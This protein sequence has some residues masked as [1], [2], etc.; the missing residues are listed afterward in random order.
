MYLMALM[1]LSD[2]WWWISVIFKVSVGLGAVIFVHELGH[3][4]V[5]KL[6]GVKCEKFMIGFDIGGYKLAKRWGETLYGI[7]ILPLGGYVKML[8][9]DDDPAHIKEQMEKSQLDPSSENA[10]PITGPDGET[11]YVDR[12]SYLAKSVP[13]RM[14]IISAGVVM[15]IIFAFIFAVIAYGMGVPYVPSIVGETMAGGPAWQAGLQP[16]DEIVKIGNRTDPTFMQLMGG[17]TLG[18]LENG[19]E[20]EV[21]R[22]A[23]GKTERVPL[24]PKR[25]EG[26]VAMIGITSPMSL[27]LSERQATM[28]DSP[29]VKATLVSPPPPQ[30]KEGEAKFQ[31][32]D[33][34]VQVGTTP[35]ANYREF[36]AQLAGQPDKP[37]QIVVERSADKQKNKKVVDQ[38]EKQEAARLTFEVPSQ[39]LKDF[40]LVM[41]IGPITAVQ[42]NTPGDAAGL[43]A[44]DVIE[45][46]DGK[47]A[48]DDSW[49]PDTLPDLMRQA[50]EQKRTVDIGVSRA[51]KNGTDRESVNVKVTPRVPT[52][53]YTAVPLGSPQGIEAL[54]IAYQIT[55]QVQAVAASGPAANSGIKAGDKITAARIV[56][57]K[58]NDGKTPPPVKLELG[59]DAQNWVA[60]VDAVQFV[61]PETFVEFK[62]SG[63][64][65][66]DARDA[67][68]TPAPVKGAFH[69]P[70]GF[71]FSPVKRTRVAATF[72]DQLRYGW[73]ET[74]DALTMVVRFLRKLGGQI[75][76][77][78][79]GGP[80]TIAAAAGGAASQG[81]SSLLIFL[82]ML[83]ANLAVLN[84]LPIPLLDG[85]HFVFL[86]YEGIRGRPA[87]EKFVIALHTAGFIFIV[88]LMLFVIGLDIKRWIFT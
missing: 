2:L 70:R 54:G 48:G 8:G 21:R 42:A 51:A 36:A 80:G 45:T 12:R 85:G 49:T 37:L 4:L 9:Q 64:G 47:P 84:F 27:T 75:P 16:G 69:A 78:M 87:N 72:S 26:Q 76:L 53:Y 35:V 82:T 68:I 19:I 52:M 34:V 46:V 38:D 39:P 67:K 31:G 63:E 18:D 11:Y 33:K 73:D 25:K 24:M 60:L 29:A 71:V 6:C 1:S 57:A 44:G 59:D 55:N 86:L 81:I 32:G 43:L 66:K 74:V 10:V 20:F 79:L 58:D 23:T 40:G 14:A 65:E 22:A 3:F 13:Q 83:S 77:T 15:N 17:V 88:G 50:A 56:L 41:K 28:D 61:S 62:V 30:V 7:G 5:A